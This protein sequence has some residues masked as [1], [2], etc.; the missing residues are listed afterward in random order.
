VLALL[1]VVGVL[2][3]L[4]L[5]NRGAD[6]STTGH[7]VAGATPPTATPGEQ[8]AGDPGT[9]RDGDGPPTSPAPPTS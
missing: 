1:V 3:W 4:L 6:A 8:G 5:R 7:H 2:T 9:A